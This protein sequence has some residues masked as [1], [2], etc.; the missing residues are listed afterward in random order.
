MSKHNF[1]CLENRFEYYSFSPTYSCNTASIY[2]GVQGGGG[3]E[4]CNGGQSVKMKTA[5]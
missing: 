3:R 4:P 1:K 5:K 2:T